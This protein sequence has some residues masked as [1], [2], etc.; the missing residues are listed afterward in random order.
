MMVLFQKSDH[1][2]DGP[3]MIRDSGFHR[4]RNAKRFV[5]SAE[6]IVHVVNCNRGDM[7]LNLFLVRVGQAGESAHVHSHGQVLPLNKAGRNVL[8]IG[9]PGNYN[10]AATDAL[11]W[12]VGR[13]TLAV[14]YIHFNQHRVINVIPEAVLNRGEIGA[15][16]VCSHLNAI[17][18]ALR[19]VLNKF[20]GASGIASGNE[21]R[22]NQLR[23]GV[24]GD[25]CP[26][27]SI[28]EFAAKF[29]RDVLF[30]GVA[31]R[32]NFVALNSF[33]SQIYQSLVEV[34]GARRSEVH[35]Q[36]CNRVLRYARHSD[37][38]ADAVSF[39]KSHYHLASLL[40][41]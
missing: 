30:F 23:I 6:V 40:C 7:I 4:G 41:C 11:R 18:K 34:I 31:K 32:P 19:Y 16:A 3:D 20:V 27:I 5:N 25:P 24:N 26:N 17:R 36:L 14:G 21:P 39:D 9:T 37:G 33:G 1:F 8:W 12:T 28:A 13:F 38:R 22:N 2:F 35:E 15:M 29:L 10:F